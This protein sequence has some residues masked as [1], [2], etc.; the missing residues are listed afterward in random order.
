M[1]KNIP[2]ISFFT[3]T[4]TWLL[5]V[6]MLV[7]NW[8]VLWQHPVYSWWTVNMEGITVH[9]SFTMFQLFGAVLYVPAISSVIVW[10]AL[11]FRH[12]YYRQSIDADIQD[13]TYLN[14]WKTIGPVHR[15]WVANVVL[16][17]IIIALAILCSSLAK[18]E[19]P[20]QQKRWDLAKTNPHFSIALDVAVARYQKLAGRY[21]PITLMRKNGVPSAVLYCLHQ[22]ESSGN[23]LCHP[24]EGSP[25]TQRTR[26]VPRGRLPQ[27]PP[28][29]NFDESAE[30]AYY[31]CDRLDLVDWT[32]VPT[33][34]QAIE[35]FNGLG[36]QKYHQDVPSPYLWSGTTIYWR[37]KYT[38]D[39]KFNRLAVDGQIG[40]AAIFKRMQE[41]GISFL[42]KSALS[43]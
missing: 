15:I 35:S 16:I 11:L 21:Q 42:S 17:G 32:K 37:G 1:N 24:H 28:P 36:Y 12:L 6:F 40:C 9:E 41:R 4:S 22:R 3:R 19:V 2:I 5:T 39:G 38:G 25:L 13:G 14:D 34:L 7:S 29:Y 33:A 30:D 18:G 10:V 20:D 8:L 31:V 27:K 23:F 26:Y 43:P